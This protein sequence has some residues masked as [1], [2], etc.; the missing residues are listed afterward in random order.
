MNAQVTLRVNGKERSLTVDTRS[1][2]LDVLRERL[3]VTSAKKGAIT[4]SAGP[5]PCC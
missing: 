3:G 1:T 2:L 4:G 5:A